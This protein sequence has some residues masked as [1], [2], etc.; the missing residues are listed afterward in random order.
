MSRTEQ[1]TGRR[2]AECGH[3]LRV[4]PLVMRVQAECLGQRFS[5]LLCLPC[6]LNHDRADAARW[7]QGRIEGRHGR[8]HAAPVPCSLDH[9]QWRAAHAR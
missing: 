3:C 5:D 7:Y 4:R 8:S 1:S 2:D 6:R 9:L